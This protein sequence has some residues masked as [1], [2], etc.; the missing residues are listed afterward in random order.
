VKKL[1]VYKNRLAVQLPD[2]VIIYEIESNDSKDMNYKG[3]K[4]ISKKFDCNLFF[5]THENL[6]ICEVTN[7]QIDILAKVVLN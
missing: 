5:V 3:K 2:K 1:A 4:S 6:I 7:R